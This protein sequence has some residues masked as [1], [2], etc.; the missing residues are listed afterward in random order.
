MVRGAMYACENQRAVHKNINYYVSLRH[1]IK[2]IF[3]ISKT[4]KNVPMLVFLLK[5]N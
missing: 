1:K 5:K 4:Y 2:S 3:Q